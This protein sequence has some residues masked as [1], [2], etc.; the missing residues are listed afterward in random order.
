MKIQ[1]DVLFTPD[2]NDFNNVKETR[3]VSI[4]VGSRLSSRDKIQ[5]RAKE[6]AARDR[7]ID[8]YALRNYWTAACCEMKVRGIPWSK[9]TEVS[10]WLRQKDCTQN[11]A[12][13]EDSWRHSIIKCQFQDEESRKKVQ[14][15]LLNKYGSSFPV[16]GTAEYMR[17]TL[18]A[19]GNIETDD[20]NQIKDIYDV[21][22]SKSN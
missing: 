3:C 20:F 9:L 10:E 15:E 7:T 22:N 21:H 12:K 17:I 11:I 19:K 5:K 18:R 4:N 1:Y 8:T 16:H 14:N 6:R 13:M 2:T